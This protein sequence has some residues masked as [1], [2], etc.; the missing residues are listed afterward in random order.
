MSQHIPNELTAIFRGDHDLLTALKTQDAHY[1]RQ[2][3]EYH[4][5]N[6]ARSGQL[7]I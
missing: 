2:A 4:E 6:R 7:A 5:V 3:E 1:S